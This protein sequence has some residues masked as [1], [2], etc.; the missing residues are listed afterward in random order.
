VISAFLY[1]P[2][3]GLQFILRFNLLNYNKQD[4]VTRM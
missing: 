1:L 3:P 4:P 2:H